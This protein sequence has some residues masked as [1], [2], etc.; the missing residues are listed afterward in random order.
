MNPED[1]SSVES[2]E[3]FETLINPAPPRSIRDHE[4]QTEGFQHGTPGIRDLQLMK[5]TTNQGPQ[6]FLTLC[7][8]S[9]IE[10][11]ILQWGCSINTL[12]C[13]LPKDFHCCM[14]QAQV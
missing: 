4:G 3:V 9:P 8:I 6:G 11:I 14:T 1:N 5:N 7:L 12:E 13:K 2:G 10:R